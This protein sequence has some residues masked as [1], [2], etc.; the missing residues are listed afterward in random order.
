MNAVRQSGGCGL[1]RVL[2][3]L[4]LLFAA[5]CAAQSIDPR[6][7]RYALNEDG[8]MPP[9]VVPVLRLVSSTHV[10]P[11]TGLVLSDSGLVL[12][13]MGFAAEGDEVIVLDGGTD[14]VRNGRPAHLKDYFPAE[15]LQI[16][17]VPGLRRQPAPF[18]TEALTDGTRVELTAFP[19][20]ER[21][22]EGDPPLHTAATVVVFGTNG[23]PAVSGETP[24]PN[25]TGPLLDEC[26][27]VAAYS[28]AHDLQTMASHPGT[29][30][31][32]RETLLAVLTRLGVTPAPSACRAAASEPPPP[33]T[34]PEP[35]PEPPP[36]EEP[37]AAEDVI[38]PPIDA[39]AEPAEE[40]T[41]EEAEPEAAEETLAIDRLP[42]IETD[43]PPPAPDAPPAWPWLLLG[44]ALIAAGAWVH[45]RRRRAAD[46]TPQPPGADAVEKP[47]PDAVD[48]LPAH[49]PQLDRR[50]ALRGVL[51]DGTPVDIGCA[52]SSRAINVVIGRGATADL[53]LASAAVSRQHARLNGTADALTVADLGSS[54]GTSVNGVPCLEG[55]ILY[56]ERGDVLVLGDAQLSVEFEPLEVA[57]P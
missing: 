41:T 6:S 7:G 37:E 32:W 48:D 47:D 24:L 45:W 39:P 13:P 1:R 50:L 43:R 21:I 12:V 3:P 33:E 9:W 5:T 10:E 34:G 52:V 44:L 36:A 38:E 18:A 2:L 26:G 31:K 27:N 51:A 40:A 20:A 56:L 11:T 14:I 15:G 23:A 55:E 46:A 22:A 35:E 49:T 57:E 4:L 42:P 30:Y 28:L 19:P 16:L 29:R 17:S 54:N 8:S 53:V 25:V